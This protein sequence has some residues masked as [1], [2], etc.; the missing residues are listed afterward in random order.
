MITS[1]TTK[2]LTAA[3]H[4]LA[5]VNTA[6]YPGSGSGDTNALTYLALGLVGET[7]EA[8][9]AVD[10]SDVSSELGDVAWYLARF[11]A[12]LGL[13]VADC[14]TRRA[15]ADCVSGALTSA[16]RVAEHVKKMLR[17]DAGQ[18]T[19]DRKSKISEELAY[20]HGSW[21]GW[22]EAFDLDPSDVR[23]KNIAKLDS[24]LARGVLG[25]DGDH[26]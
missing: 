7:V 10:P 11:A 15:D 19:P 9:G 1:L 18:L 6:H 25:G 20:L 12:E 23:G 13:E 5:T 3:E 17:D 24:R 8:L 2:S 16:G 26:R 4:Q 14:F 21:V 22:C